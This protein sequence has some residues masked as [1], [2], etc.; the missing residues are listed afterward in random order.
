MKEIKQQ[1][2]IWQTKRLIEKET[3]KEKRQWTLNKEREDIQKWKKT[4]DV[5]IL[6]QRKQ[7][8]FELSVLEK[9]RRRKKMLRKKLDKEQREGIEDFDRN[10]KRLGVGGDE[11]EELPEDPEVLKIERITPFQH[12]ERLKKT[13]AAE[14]KTFAAPARNY[15][16]QLH[17]KRISDK[18]ARKEREARQRKQDV[19]QKKAQI[20]AQQSKEEAKLLRKLLG[21]GSAEREEAHVLWEKRQREKRA[22]EKRRFNL[23]LSKNRYNETINA[24][25]TDFIEDS[26]AKFEARKMRR[27]KSGQDSKRLAK[28]DRLL[29]QLKGQGG[30]KIL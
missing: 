22:T 28:K 8:E 24:Y 26:K 6:R 3:L 20:D 5:K 18:V 4:Q 15:M 23:Q 10:R 25:L 9:Q 21:I 2:K 11:E 19:D 14:T 29:K 13:V 1:K 7:L 12:L 16:K 30:L 17:A 27:R